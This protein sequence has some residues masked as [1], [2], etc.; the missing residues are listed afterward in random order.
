MATS[1]PTSYQEANGIRVLD[2]AS[3]DTIMQKIDRSRTERLPDARTWDLCL[4]FLEGRQYLT[5][6]KLQNQFINMPQATG[7]SRVVINKLLNK[8]RNVVSRLSAQYP[9]IVVTGSTDS[10]EELVKSEASDLSLKWYWA[11]QDMVTKAG[12]AVRWLTSVGNTALHTLYDENKKKIVTKVISPYNLFWEPGINNPDE[13]QWVAIMS[14][15]PRKELVDTYPQFK[16]QLEEIT[17]ESQRDQKRPGGGFTQGGL[18]VP[19]DRLAFY[20]VCY[21]DGRCEFRCGPTLVLHS[22]TTPGNVFP[23]QF[24]R[25]TDVPG[26]LWGLGLLVQLLDLQSMYNRAR[27]LVF[28]SGEL[29]ANPMWLI[30]KNAGLSAD[31]ISN[32][33]GKKVFYNAAAPEPKQV[34]GAELPVYFQNSIREID[35]E[36]NDVAGT[37]DVQLGKRP[38]NFSSGTAIAEMTQNAVSQLQLTQD[39]IEAAFKQHAQVVLVFMKAYYTEG[40]FIKMLDVNGRMVSRTVKSTDLLDMPCIHLEAGT[41]FRDSAEDRDRRTIQMMQAGLIDKEEARQ[42]LS[43][44]IG[45]RDAVKRMAAYAHAEELLKAAIGARDTFNPVTGQMDVKGVEIWPTDDLEAI[46]EVFSEY[47]RSANYPLLPDGR[48]QYVRDI[49]MAV[50]NFGQPVD[51]NTMDQ[52]DNQKVWPLQPK[53][54]R[55]ATQ[56]IAGSSTP[57]AGEQI[58]QEA[59]QM[60][61]RGAELDAM[62]KLMQP[63]VQPAQPAPVP[64]MVGEGGVQ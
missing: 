44:H 7:R 59:Q 1:G 24:I 9:S 18:Q 25:Y 57:L 52:Q 5:W 31:A 8:Y 11:D 21:R 51:P 26:R 13:A 37:N 30:A 49:L 50:R 16:E 61:G 38:V 27:N 35:Q 15:V 34:K 2:H 14:L 43:F 17:S 55:E 19:E 32:S 33:P 48:Q 46:R 3:D 22:W 10:Y 40:Q 56:L 6:D 23:V 60:A 39:N 45:N 53:D 63:S 4:A 36:M 54:P 64:G 12:D 41:L 47:V 62:R 42:R 29:M 20:E 28:D 58:A